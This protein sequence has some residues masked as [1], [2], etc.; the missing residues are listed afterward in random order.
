[1]LFRS[2]VLGEEIFGFLFQLNFWKVG[3]AL[4]VMAVIGQTHH[5]T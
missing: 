5:F 3:G 1:M 2:A 4:G